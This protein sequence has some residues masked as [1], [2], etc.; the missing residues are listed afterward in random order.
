M[1]PDRERSCGI[2]CKVGMTLG[3]RVW[4][5][6]LALLSPL[7]AADWKVVWSDEF[8]RPG[9][10]DPTKWAYEKGF[11]RNQELQFYT[12]N[13][14]ENARVENGSLLIEARHEAFPNPAFKEGATDWAKSRKQAEYTS[15]ALITQGLKSFRYGKIE[16][17]AK[18]PGGKGIWPAIWMLGDSRGKA[19]WPA[20]GEIDIMEFVSHAPKV[21]HGTMHFAKPGTAKDHASEGGK[22]LCDTLHS[23]F[24]VYGVEWDEKTIQIHFDGKPY[25]TFQIDHAGTGEDNPFRKPFYLLLNVAVGGSWG[26]DPDPAVYPQR[27]E[28]DWV[29]VS[30]KNG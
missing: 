23:D 29:R 30:E 7:R 12:V 20:C 4:M 15:A 26:R 16:V 1:I 2:F 19:P 21:V 5:V 8:D 28:I 9:A 6:G 14:R 25:F 22:T 3:L 18:I 17:R 13:R 10:P 11:V 24:H 27:M